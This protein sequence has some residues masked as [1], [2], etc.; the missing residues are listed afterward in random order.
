LR[1][2]CERNGMPCR[3][4]SD[5]HVKVY[6]HEVSEWSDKIEKGYTTF[7][8]P[9]PALQK[10]LEKRATQIT[11]RREISRGKSKNKLKNRNSSS[12]STDCG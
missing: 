4:I 8:Q 10:T 6:S 12:L 3:L 5:V 9:H 2:A 11:D 1:E 7:Q